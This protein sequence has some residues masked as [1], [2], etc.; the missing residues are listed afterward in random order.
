[1]KFD[2]IFVCTMNL[3]VQCIYI[4]HSIKKHEN[5]IYFEIDLN[6][7][8]KVSWF[9]NIHGLQVL[10]CIC[11]KIPDLLPHLTFI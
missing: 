2:N 11:T 1:M 8:K 4:F 7:G 3:L 9:L 5:S 10:S 6:K